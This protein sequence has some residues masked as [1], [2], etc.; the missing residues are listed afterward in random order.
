[1]CPVDYAT[2]GATLQVST[3]NGITSEKGKLYHEHLVDR[4]VM[5]LK[6]L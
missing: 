5:V 4:L 1:M 2:E 3:K 6:E